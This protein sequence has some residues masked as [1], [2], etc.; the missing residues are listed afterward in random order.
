MENFRI[1]ENFS[2]IPQKKNVGRPK[3]WVRYAN[4]PG[5]N[6]ALFSEGWNVICRRSQI[7]DELRMRC[8]SALGFIENGGVWLEKYQWISPFKGTKEKQGKNTILYALGRIENDELIR[9][10]ADKICEQKYS[11]ATACKFIKNVLNEI[12]K[13]GVVQ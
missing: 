1:M 13:A 12:K 5:A 11:A 10:L 8:I 6:P 2:D 7:N 9:L 3:K 4:R